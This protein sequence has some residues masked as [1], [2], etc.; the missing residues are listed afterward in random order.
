MTIAPRNAS[1]RWQTGCNG[2]PP[3]TKVI[4]MSTPFNQVVGATANDTSADLYEVIRPQVALAE[5]Q[6]RRATFVPLA[7]LLML[8]TVVALEVSTWCRWSPPTSR[9]DNS[10]KS[11]AFSLPPSAATVIPSQ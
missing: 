5:R 6:V 9:T 7:L 3:K 10:K 1:G 2:G 4:K 11:D 8:A